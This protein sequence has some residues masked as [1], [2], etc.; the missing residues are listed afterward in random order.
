[1]N[2]TLIGFLVYL[3]LI[4]A[5]GLY[6]YRINKSQNDYFIAGR[7]LNPWL[8]AFSER[9]SGESAWLLVGLP[10]AAFAA[11]LIEFWTALGCV[12]GIIAS[13]YLIAQSLREETE[14]SDAIT[15]PNFFANK[16]GEQGSAIRVVATLIIVFFFTFYLAAQFN[17]AGKVLLTTFDIPFQYGIIIGAFAI[18]LYTMAGG[19]LAVVWTD[20]VQGTI[21]IIALVVMPIVG[22][23]E[24]HE[25]GLS[26]GGAMAEHGG[27]FTSF[28]GNLTGW[29]AIAAVVGG[30]SWGL[31]YFGQPHLLARFMAIKDPKKIRIGRRIAITWA[32]PAFAGAMVLG[33]VGLALYGDGYFADPEYIMPIL[34][35][36]LLPSWIAGIFISGAIAAMMSTAD[37]QLLVISSSFVE[38]FYRRTLKRNPPD[39][40]LLQMSRA[41]TLI[42]G[43]VGY[44]IAARSQELVFD[45]VSYAWAGLGASF[46]P[47]IILTLKW[48]KTTGAGVL[49]GMI[50]GAASTFVWNSFDALDDFISTRFV[51]FALAFAT[52]VFVSLG[53][54]KEVIRTAHRR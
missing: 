16:F 30:L 18:I 35:N 6:T 29:A 40:I 41:V 37:S 8:V 12:L 54:Q 21:M 2:P 13:W 32:I 17:A 11:G 19:F 33:L 26:L 4:F 10:G 1:M 42:V 51:A 7:N 15:I 34:A 43:L 39:K 9:A 14:R 38:D 24:I 52:I 27:R 22:V 31:G 44:A 36:T 3:V 23:I 45:L 49:A 5:V 28:V 46:G 53:T 50:V 47:A 25:Q 20:F 48:K